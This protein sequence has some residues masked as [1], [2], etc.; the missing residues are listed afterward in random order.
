MYS[1]DAA[2]IMSGCSCGGKAFFFIR[3]VAKLKAIND[4]LRE[5]II[6]QAPEETLVVDLEHVKMEDGK[7]ELDLHA[8]LGRKEIVFQ[9]DEGKYD[10]DLQ[11][12]FRRHI[13][14]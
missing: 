8:M 12:S 9:Y 4:D 6:E 7:Y 1:D 13:E 3:N 10:I 14:K 5:A 2:E 11:E